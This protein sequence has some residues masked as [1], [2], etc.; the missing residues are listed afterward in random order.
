MATN[1]RPALRPFEVPSH[2]AVNLELELAGQ[3]DSEGA[4]GDDGRGRDYFW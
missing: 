2:A 3:D 4:Q 1:L